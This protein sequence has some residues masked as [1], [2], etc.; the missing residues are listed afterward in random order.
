MI[1]FSI[2]KGALPIGH[3]PWLVQPV[4][5]VMQVLV[6]PLNLAI[7]GAQLFALVCVFRLSWLKIASIL[8]D[9]LHIGIYVLGGLFFWPWIWN[10]FTILIAATVQKKP[11]ALSAKAVCVFTILLLGFPQL[12]VHGAAWLAWFDVVDARQTYFEAVTE[13]GGHYRVPSSFFLSHSYSVSHRVMDRVPHPGQY[14]STQWASTKDY[15]RF[16]TS[17]SCPP[18]PPVD[19]RTLETEK[20]HAARLERIGRFIRA[21]HAKMLER[22]AWL[23]SGSYYFRLHHHPSNP[24]LFTRWN[25][26]KLDQVIGYNLV[27]ESVCHRLS[28]GHVEKTVVGHIEDFF[29]VR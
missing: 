20:Q 7:V 28:E 9:L 18:P 25:G 6:V 5:D 22:E 8:Y 4:Y 14:A 2:E 27:V 11:I 12:G 26:I 23:G 15:Q 24:F 21:H 3:L 16:L 10:N 1:P 19:P 29:S 17:G 13:D